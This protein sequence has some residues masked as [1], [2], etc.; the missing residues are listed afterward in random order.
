[1]KARL[2]KRS[3]PPWT[4]VIEAGRDPATG[5][6]HRIYKAVQGNKTRAKQE[7]DML[8]A[9]LH[10]GTYAAPSRTT[11][12]EYLARIILCPTARSKNHGALHSML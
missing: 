11:L 10:Q 12:A 8:L 1:M 4:V 6:R 2:E 7:M 5:K 3:K 9:E